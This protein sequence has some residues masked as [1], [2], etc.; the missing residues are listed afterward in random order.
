MKHILPM[1]LTKSSFDRMAAG[2]CGGIAEY[3]GW[4]ANLVRAAFVFFTFFSIGSTAIVYLLMAFL[5]P[6]E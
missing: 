1:K 3:F 2:V 4:N 6:N 5:M